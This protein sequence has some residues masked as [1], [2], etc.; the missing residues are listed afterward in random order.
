MKNLLLI[1]FMTLSLDAC[2]K[3]SPPPF[4]E[5]KDQDKRWRAC[6]AWEV[7]D[8]SEVGKMCNRV[9]LKRSKGVCEK[10]KQNIK[11]FCE[12]SDFEFYRSSTFIFID[13]DNL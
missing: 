8:G 9:C 4:S 2:A 12:K 10:W 11:N 13:E 5:R 1:I 3:G 7:K 6:E